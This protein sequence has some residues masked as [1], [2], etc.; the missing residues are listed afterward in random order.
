MSCDETD[1]TIFGD[2]TFKIS[3]A[4]QLLLDAL[5]KYA[6]MLD[7]VTNAEEIG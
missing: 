4:N 3:T 1:N 5:I 7:V 2:C 6:M